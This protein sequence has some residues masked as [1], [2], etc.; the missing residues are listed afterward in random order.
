MWGVGKNCVAAMK[1]AILGFYSFGGQD[2]AYIFC[3][4]G[5]RAPLRGAG[6][7]F[8]SNFNYNNIDF[9]DDFPVIFWYI[10]IMLLL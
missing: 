6:F 9:S 3:S 8:G 4:D 2:S 1:F 7:Q 5:A 10:H